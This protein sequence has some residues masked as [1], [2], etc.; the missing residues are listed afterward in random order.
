M[1]KLTKLDNK[2]ELITAPLTDSQTVTVLVMVKVGSRHESASLNGISH[3]IEHLMFKGTKKRPSSLMI[4]KKL[5]GVGAEFNA[6]TG[7]EYTGYYVKVSSEHLNLA[8]DILSDMLFNPLFPEKEINK[9]RGVIIEEINMYNDNPLMLMGD[10]F[11]ETL[12][13]GHAL[14]RR[15]IGP[16][17]NIQKIS[18]NQILKYYKQHYLRGKIIVGVA[19]NFEQ[20][21]I[22]DKVNGYFGQ[23]KLGQSSLKIDNFKSRQRSKRINLLYRETEQVQLAL[24]FP[25]VKK[26]SPDKYPLAVLAAVLGGNMSSRLFSQIREKRGLAYFVKAALETFQD[27]GAFVVRAGLDKTKMELALKTILSEL[28]KVR[29]K[30][31]SQAELKMAKEFIK[32]KMALQF[33]D[34]TEVISWLIEQKL[35]TGRIED[36]QIKKNKVD[37]VDLKAVKKIARQIIDFKKFNLALIGPFEDKKYF[38]K[39]IK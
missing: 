32:G 26:T 5:D 8:L 16:K 14:G 1:Y 24:G 23:K 15:I 31:I 20:G 11:E 21:S 30:G 35:L 28:K 6:F 25:A 10:V 12:F 18:R 13:D 38:E 7:K 19:G 3:F 29:D 34:S 33:E 2:I 37:Q 27:T 9:E 22:K 36:R 17:E 4:T 39:L